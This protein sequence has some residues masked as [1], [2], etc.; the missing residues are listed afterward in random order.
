MEN[1]DLA[2]PLPVALMIKD[3]FTTTTGPLGGWSEET[4]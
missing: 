4:R 3:E 2:R 1:S